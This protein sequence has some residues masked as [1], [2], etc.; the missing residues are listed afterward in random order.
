VHFELD[1][2]RFKVKALRRDLADE[3]GRRASAKEY[4]TASTAFGP[5][6]WPRSTGGSA[7]SKTKGRAREESSGPARKKPRIVVRE[8]PAPAHPLLA[9]K[10]KRRSEHG[11]GEEPLGKTGN[12]P[13]RAR[14][15]G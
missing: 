11:E 5:A 6:F 15:A 10:M 14:L 3:T 8:R 2:K 1:A 7:S 12:R 9:Q 13:R 4:T